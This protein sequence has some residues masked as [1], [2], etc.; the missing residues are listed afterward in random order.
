MS[1]QFDQFLTEHQEINTVGIAGHISPDGD[2]IGSCT[3]LYLY[4]KKN[5]PQFR[6]DIFMEK[7]PEELRILKGTEDI[8]TSFTSDVERY[9]VFFILDTIKERTNAAEKLFDKAA[10]RVNFDHHVSN[11]GTDGI[12]FIVPEASSTCEVLCMALDYDKMDLDIARNIYSGIVTDT[13]MFHYSSTSPATM[14]AAAKLMEFGFDHS[15][16]IE[17]V[18]LAKRFSQNKAMGAM[19]AKASLE[20]DG[21]V[22]TSFCSTDEMHDLGFVS[23]DFEGVVSQMNLTVGVECA[24]FAHGT[25]DGDVRMN[26]RSKGKV[27][28]SEIAV[29]VGGG[30][31]VRAS[32][33]TMHN[34]TCEESISLILDKI[35]E[36]L[37]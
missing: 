30:G 8:R 28:V 29:S 21:K 6:V 19:L 12:C 31:H 22:I 2:C 18:E 13:G 25:E 11:K 20:L 15:D 10:L 1:F 33:C 9:D 37:N 27:N 7:V 16:L 17:Q 14:R 3:G 35:K 32:G 36:Q 5:Y 23:E 26:L 4:L 34:M 24:V